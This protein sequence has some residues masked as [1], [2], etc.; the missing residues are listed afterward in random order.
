MG[1]AAAPRRGE[2]LGRAAEL[3]RAKERELGE[4]VQVE[5]GKP[6]KNGGRVASSA[7]LGVFMAQRRQPLLRQDDDEPGAESQRRTVRARSRLRRDSCRSTVPWPAWAWRS[8]GAPLRERRRRQSHELTPYTAVAFG[9][10]LHE[11][12]LPRGVYSVVQGLG[13]KS[14]R[15]SSATIASPRQ[16]Q[17]ARFPR[18]RFSRAQRAARCSAKVCLELGGKNPLVVCDDAE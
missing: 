4:I 2:V 1:P 17:P 5:T 3:L 15:R 8:S 7:D 13:S 12:G 14:A 16:L 6:W 10:L 11:A 9:R 18:S